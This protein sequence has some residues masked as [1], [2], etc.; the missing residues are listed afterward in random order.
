MNARTTTMNRTGVLVVAASLSC[1]AAD[2]LAAEQSKTAAA[3]AS[4]RVLSLVDSFPADKPAT[5]D[6]LCKQIL[7]LG[8]AG[9]SAVLARVL[10]P[11]QDDTKARYAVNGIVVYS[12]RAGATAERALVANALL[13]AVA[14]ATNDDVATFYLSQLRLVAGRDLIRPLQSRLLSERL[15]APTAAVLVTVGG[16]EASRALLGALDKAPAGAKVTIVDALGALR[17]R[18]A[19][20]ALLPLAESSDAALRTAARTALADIGDPA[21]TATLS[22]SRID[23]PVRERAAAPALLLRQARRLAESGQT[24]EALTAARTI[25]D[26]YRRPGES[27]YAAE[28]LALVVA[29]RKDESLADL[30]AALDSPDRTLRGA[31]LRLASRIPGEAATSRWVE[32]AQA[33]RPEPRAEMVAMLGDRGD[34]AALPLVRDSLRSAD[35]AVRLAAVPAAARLGRE[36]VLPDLFEQLAKAEADECPV[37]KQALLGYPG[38]QVAPKALERLEATALPAKAVLIELLG[39]KRAREATATIYRL[40]GDTEPAT[41]EA[42]LVALANLAG[43]ADVPRLVEMLDKASGGDDVVRL[44]EAITAAVLRNPDPERRA[45]GLLALLQKA[46]AA[47][48]IAILRVLPRVGGARPLHAVA[49]EAASGEPEVQAAAVG[50]I[51]RWPD[52]SAAEDLLRIASTST[53]AAHSRTALQ[54]YVRLV[55]RSEMPTHEKMS[56]FEQ[57][58]AVPAADADRK[59]LLSAIASVREPESLRLLGRCL[60]KPELRDAAAA[61]LLNLASQ[62]APEERWLSGH[63]AYSLLR[64]AEALQPDAARRERAANTIRE[65]LKQGGFVPLFDGRSLEGWKG[66]AADAPARAR[67]TKDA[68]A[69]AQAAADPKLLEHWK[70]VDGALVSDGQG[71]GLSTARDYGDFELLA[72]WKI[73]KG[74]QGGVSLRDS[75]QVQ[76]RDAEADPVGSGALSSNEKPSQPLSKADR[77]AGEWNSFRVLMIGDRV[78]VYL[79]DTRVVAEAALESDAERGGSPR[80]SAGTSA[81]APGMSRSD[82]PD[83]PAGPI[84][85]QAHGSPVSFRNLYV[86]EIPRATAAPT[87]ATDAA[88]GFS[89]LFNGKDLSGWT[90]NLDGYAAEDGK[91]VVHPERKG[92]NL[93]TEKEYTDFVLR[94]E[95][96]LPPAANNG[97]G[98]RAPL[99]G[100]AA[101]AGMEVQVLEDGSPVYWGLEPYQY[102][103]SVYGVVPAKRGA[104]E[105]IGQWNQEEITVEGRHVTVVVNGITVV[106]ADL[107][108][109]SAKG[110]LDHKE[111]PGLARTSGHIG[112][113]GHGDRVEF[114]NI[115]I[116]E[117]K[118]N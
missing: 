107:D 38:A 48:K 45:D 1:L 96:K 16:P 59:A 17:S 116:R 78:T 27:Q 33:A 56:H 53:N 92:G 70:V 61:A 102:H 12:G 64:R 6:A 47:G 8:P 84:G 50:A 111:H 51:A 95:F 105:P 23:V 87:S 55:A 25:L 60:G 54:G 118:A 43:E 65:R 76:I 77:P 100:D 34:A 35:K 36:S 80:P 11:G 30:L 90:G 79:N 57:A 81:A 72:D 3:H 93:Y 62:Q 18:E 110:T 29:L 85:L 44:R 42:S 86:R 83:A 40:A 82:R 9:V 112:F 39:E 41:R 2:P 117:L 52:L 24:A 106:D 101:Y 13:A 26:A 97:I 99:E 74:G 28:A 75:A 73:E 104:L 20:K 19:V 114:R 14:G 88:E 37:F 15:G 58:L 71:E 94:F 113:L 98:I 49:Q 89:P 31:A 68:L 67:T 21:A 32:K 108:K 5:R 103:G 109:A 91:I 66:L 63:E 22:R 69:R 10:P 46:P 4:L 115:R 7:D